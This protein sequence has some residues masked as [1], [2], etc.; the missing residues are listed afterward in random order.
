MRR[1]AFT[2]IELLVVISI[3]ALLIGIL[4]PA[5]GAARKTARNMQCMSNLRGLGQAHA[6]YGN[7]NKQNIVPYA[8]AEDPGNPG[9]TRDI[10]WFEDLATT[11]IEESREAG[12]DRVDF[13]IDEFS[14]PE[15]DS[16]A[17]N[18]GGDSKAGYGMNLRVDPNADEE[19]K[20]LDSNAEGGFGVD[21]TVWRQYDKITNATEFILNGDSY[22]P[23]IKPSIA[24]G[25]AYFRLDSDPVEDRWASGEP[26][27]HSGMDFLETMKA[28]YVFVDGHA[29]V[30]DGQDA[31]VMI[32]DPNG[33]RGLVGGAA[34]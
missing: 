3:I 27:R 14:C 30:V 10:F 11:M 24:S 5:L 25:E 9:S 7:D 18:P 6:V 16:D 4:L 1:N 20:P 31:A 2:L 22:E 19:Y 33:T 23:H 12:E 21:I 32:R 15:F 17:R 29:E 26:D 34:R 8:R 28:N 13:V